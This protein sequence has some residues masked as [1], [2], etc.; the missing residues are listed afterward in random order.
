MKDSIHASDH[1]QASQPLRRSNNT[2]ITAYLL[3][4]LAV[5]APTQV[6]AQNCGGNGQRACCVAEAPFGAC[7]TGLL[8]IPGCVG[9]CQCSNNIFQSSSSCALPTSCGGLNERACCVGESGFGACQ[10]GL[11]ENAYPDAG[12]CTNLPGSQSSSVC[13]APTSCGGSDERACCA[14]EQPFGACQVGLIEQPQANSGQCNN[15]APGI[16][17]QGMCRTIETCGGDGQ[18]A[19]CAGE[20][21]FGACSDGLAEISQANAGQCG[22]LAWGIQSNSV[23]QAVTSCGGQGERACCLGESGFGACQA[24]LVELP[25]PN[26]GYCANALDTQSNSICQE[27]TSCGGPNERA[28]CAGEQPFGACEAGLVEEPLAN[29][30]QCSNLAPGIESQGI[31]RTTTSCGADGERACCAGE[32]P[33]GACLAGHVEIPQA[34][35]GQCS[36]LAWGIQ[37]DSVCQ[38]VTSCG[39]T[40]ERAC[41][42]N[43]RPFGACQPGANEVPGCDGD[44]LCDTGLTAN[45]TCVRATPCGGLG[46][47]AC[48]LGEG[49]ACNVGNDEV[50]GCVGDCFCGPNAISGA[51]FATSSCGL[52]TEPSGGIKQISEPSVNCTDCDPEPQA[53][54]EFCSLQGF[55]DMHAHMFAHLAHGGAA[56]VGKPYDPNGG[57]NEALKQDYGTDM[58]VVG[59]YEGGA[60]PA[61]V[62]DGLPP[63]CPDYL[64]NTGVCNGQV[65]WH[66]DHQI[67]DD[68]TGTGSNDQPGSPLGAPLFNGWPT[69]QSAVHQQMYYKWLERAYRGGMRHMV[70]MAV[71]SEAMC[72]VSV[73]LAGVDCADSMGQIDLQ[74]QAAYDFQDWLDAQS[75]GV[76][77]GWFRIVDSP[78][79]ARRVI[80]NGK[81]AVTIGIEV[82]NLFNCKATGACPNMPAHPELDT[83]QKAI[84]YYYD[85]GVRHIFPVHNFDNAFAGAA[86]WLDPL[87]VGN[88]YIEYQW[89][90]GQDCE[91][92]PGAGT[93][94]GFRHD[95]VAIDF[96][97]GLACAV[98]NGPIESCDLADIAPPYFTSTTCNT[99]G[100]TPAGVDLMQRLMA[101]GMLIDIDHMSSK[102]LDE[103]LDL[104]TAQ[105]SY[106]LVASHGQFFE[107]HPQLY[108]D[109][110]TPGVAGQAGRH[111]RMRTREQLDRMRDLGGLVALLTLDGQQ[112]LQHVPSTASGFPTVES[113]CRESTKNWIQGYQY[114]VEVMQGPVALGTDFNGVAAHTG[115]R[116]GSDGCGG[117]VG[118]VDLTAS[119]KEERSAQ[120]RAGNQLVY[121]FTNQFGTFDRQVT[122]Q[123]I[124]D[125]NTDGLAHIGL[126]PDMLADI[127]QLGMTDANMEPLYRSANRYLE[128]WETALGTTCDINDIESSDVIF[129]DS[130]E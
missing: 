121:P 31:C 33:F 126:L 30:G 37:S 95:N 119:R 90:T 104:A 63:D 92:T 45:S 57:I 88:R 67:L 5:L 81:L 8:E 56:F 123:Q 15:L 127:K 60:P 53:D 49:N 114:A 48:C 7:M 22:N 94:Y 16:E 14:G 83:V 12:Y 3:L 128:V 85:W 125:F 19:C 112:S 43:E 91:I 98:S 10:G 34:N 47:R 58:N 129:M 54:L 66:G 18:R 69:N 117:E 62:D 102:A 118:V 68:P 111:E 72:E 109:P 59:A 4:F 61:H 64:L 107:L 52:M 122:G 120:E 29:T 113:D 70:M 25:Y 1:S 79:E 13:L 50:P 115:P 27:P 46:Q 36:N 11:V 32:Q 51:V 84:D 2:F 41:C 42:V 65:L 77:Q 97:R 87:A 108:G 101:K 44:C 76:G 124:Y 40:G 78:V 75:G 38:R 99:R 96:L 35:A 17:S 28:C 116:F 24:G 80:L 71:H 89:Q 55:S 20:A 74:I 130:F 9:D 86:L 26:A 82:D 6:A 21:G 105:N 100:L 103:S 110:T 106:P 73:Q 93:G 39:G 23:C